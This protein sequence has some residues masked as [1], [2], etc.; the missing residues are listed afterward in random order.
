MKVLQFLLIS[1]T[2][3]ASIPMVN[4]M[5]PKKSAG[6]KTANKREREENRRPATGREAADGD[7]EPQSGTNRQEPQPTPAATSHHEAAETECVI[8]MSDDSPVTPEEQESIRGLFA[9]GHMNM[10]RACLT[11]WAQR[12][13]G[14]G[15]CPM[16][17]APQTGQLQEAIAG[18]IGQIRTQRETALRHALQPLNNVIIRLARDRTFNNHLRTVV[19]DLTILARHPQQFQRQLRLARGAHRLA[20]MFNHT[21]SVLEGFRQTAISGLTTLLQYGN[22]LTRMINP[23]PVDLPT[24]EQNIRTGATHIQNQYGQAF[25][26]ATVDT[27]RRVALI[28]PELRESIDP[29]L[30]ALDAHMGINQMQAVAMPFLQPVFIGA[31][32][33]LD[34]LA[35]L[36]E[37]AFN[38]MMAEYGQTMDATTAQAVRDLYAAISELSTLIGSLFDRPRP[39]YA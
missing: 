30:A 23:S 37:T 2:F 38:R 13:D 5:P 8:C 14:N 36:I 11:E 21:P 6:K 24:L 10:H 3:S 26:Q 39:A 18:I 12:N 28:S 25:Q 31:A 17:R 9:C 27:L 1:L 22:V 16:C 15:R 35:P 32:M 29:I 20:A 19:R 33:N 7:D 4:A 34:Q